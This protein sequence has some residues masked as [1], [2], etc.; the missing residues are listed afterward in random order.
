MAAITIKFP[1][2]YERRVETRTSRLV[3]DSNVFPV[4]W[5]KMAV[6]RSGFILCKKNCLVLVHNDGESIRIVTVNPDGTCEV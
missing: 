1:F 6:T 2:H 4:C 5:T 3:I